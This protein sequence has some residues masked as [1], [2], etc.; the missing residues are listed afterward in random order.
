MANRF[1]FTFDSLNKLAVPMNGRDEY[2]DSKQP[3][4]MLRVTSNGT[5][6][7]AIAKK[8]NGT[9]KRVTLGRFPELTISQARDLAIE[10]L[11][12]LRQGIDPVEQKRRRF[13]ESTTLSQV[14]EQYLTARDHKESTKKSYSYKINKYFPTWLD[15]P[16]ILIT[17]DM[18]LKRHKELTKLGKTTANT[19]MRV[20]RAVLKYAEAISLVDKPATDILSKARLWHKSVRK[21]TIIPSNKLAEWYK[22][23]LVLDNHKHRTLLLTYLFTG[24]RHNEVLGLEWNNVDLE[25]QILTVEDTKNRR[26]HILPIPVTLVSYFKDLYKITGQERYVFS[27]RFEGTHMTLPKRQI[28]SIGKDIDH[29]FTP[30]DLR[31]TFATIAEAVHIPMSMIKRLLNHATTNDVTG[32]Y[33]MTEEETLRVAINKVADYIQTRVTK[34]DNI[35]TLHSSQ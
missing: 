3:K 15:S 13:A 22:A 16:V 32:G 17:E 5:K 34:K 30:H 9:Y 12:S 6:S 7:F 8:Q 29:H 33:I 4:L 19:A 21:M 28:T 25:E 18:V 2:Y 31:R 11:N 1:N 35:I 23:V 10:A 14:F 24:M 20:L 26:D 27:G